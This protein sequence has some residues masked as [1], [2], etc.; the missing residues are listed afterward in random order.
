LLGET[1]DSRYYLGGSLMAT[2]SVRQARLDHGKNPS[3]PHCRPTFL[4]P[5]LIAE[6]KPGT[7]W[8]RD[9]RFRKKIDSNADRFVTH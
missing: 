9:S 6:G 1:A 3:F 7:K 2:P 4:I 5:A 8:R